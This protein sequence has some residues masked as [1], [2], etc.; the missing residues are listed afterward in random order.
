ML[1]IFDKTRSV[2]AIDLSNDALTRAVLLSTDGEH[3]YLEGWEYYSEQDSGST[4]FIQD[5]KPEAV[6]VVLGDGHTLCFAVPDLSPFNLE[7]EKRKRGLLLE[8]QNTDY[9]IVSQSSLLATI[10]K[11]TAE[12]VLTSV[13]ETFPEI[14]CFSIN[15]SLVALFYTYLRSYQPHSE[16]RV[17]L[18]HWSGPIISLLVVQTEMPIWEGSI[19][20]NT[21]DPAEIYTEISTLLQTAREKLNSTNYDLLLL[22]GDCESTDVKAFQGLAKQV[23]LFSPYRNKAFEFGRKLGLRRKDAQQ[24]GH[25]LATAIGSAGMFLEGLGINLATTDVQLAHEIPLNRIVN[26]E[27]TIFDLLGSSIAKASALIFALI[28]TQGQI[29]LL[30]LLVALSLFGYGYY[31]QYQEFAQINLQMAQEHERATQL[32]DARTKHD[33]YNRKIEAINQRLSIINE[34]RKNQLTIKTVFNEVDSRIPAGLVFG[35]V[36]VT[37]NNVKIKG[38]APERTAVFAFANRLGQSLG[39]FADVVPVYDDKTNIGNYEISC[40]YIGP[41]PINNIPVPDIP[42]S[43]RKKEK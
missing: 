32:V 24:D 36:D 16:M 25:R 31:Q 40:K 39:V 10:R 2:V 3:Y 30:G 28:M 5:F 14:P 37:D 15:Q 17:G 9:I 34:I 19:E 27:K 38:Y 20:I 13:K 8:N 4:D 7:I 35:E 26:R 21:N 43:I 11:E 1:K 18:L 22:A 33:E 41:I 12:E 29:L 42:I 6:T 23:E